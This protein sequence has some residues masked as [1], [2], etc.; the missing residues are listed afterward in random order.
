MANRVLGVG[1]ILRG[2][3]SHGR[4]TRDPRTV[5]AIS[6]LSALVAIAILAPAIAPYDP[7]ELNLPDQL[8]PPSAAHWFGTD[9]TGFDIFSRV[10]HA[11][12]LDLLIVV[13][14]VALSIG[15]GV[16]I[17]VAVGY[18]GGRSDGVTMRLFDVIQAFPVLVLAIG[19]L[20]T[21]GRG[22]QNI[23]LVIGLIGVPIFVRL[24]RTQVRSLR[25]LAYVEAARSVGNDPVRLVRRYIVPGTVGVVAVQAATSCGWALLLVAGLGFLGLGVRIPDPEWGSMVS[26]GVDDML[27]GQWWTSVFPGLAIVITVFVFNLLGEVVADGV[28]PRRRNPR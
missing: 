12:R 22:T 4:L 8:Q 27:N 15:I 21:L 6:M 25:E 28:D 2:I 16:P 23:V 5:I 9:R 13:T 14:S 19:V 18:R 17:G 10:V 1:W 3:N 7:T 11:T 24:V 20:A 26:S